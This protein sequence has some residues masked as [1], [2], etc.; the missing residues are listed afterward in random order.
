VTRQL[1]RK[2]FNPRQLVG[3]FC[4]ETINAFDPSTGNLLGTIDGANGM[5]LVNWFPRGTTSQ[6]CGELPSSGTCNKSH[7][8]S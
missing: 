4:D 2:D 7:R 6:S 8:F 1:S 5:P 3:D